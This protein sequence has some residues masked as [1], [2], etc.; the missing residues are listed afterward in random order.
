MKLSRRQTEVL[1]LLCTGAADKQ[2]AGELHLSI[3]MVRKHL[4]AAAAKLSATSRVALAICYFRQRHGSR[5]DT[6]SGRK[7]GARV[8]PS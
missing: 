1:E 5:N 8:L 4:H 7:K 3:S 6:Y 2:I